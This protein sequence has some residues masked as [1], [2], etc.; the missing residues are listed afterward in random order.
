M[1]DFNDRIIAEFRE[2]RGF[3][4]TNGF[5]SN[6][7]LLHTTGARSGEARLH[8]VFA[9]EDDAG[10]FVAASKAGA[11]TDP[12]WAHNLRAH[13]RV[14]VETGTGDVA[15]EAVELAGAERDAAYARFEERSSGFSQY[16]ERAGDRVIPVF[17]L[18]R[19]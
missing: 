6:L 15:A 19:T 10:W 8:P 16:Q 5:G 4:S 9:V 2:N 13:P 11:P 14:T 17:A 18:R 12:A 7:V 3:V 1:S